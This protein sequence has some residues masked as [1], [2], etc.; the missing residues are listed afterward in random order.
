MTLSK[1]EK[2]FFNVID[3]LFHPI[4]I[5]LYSLYAIIHLY[6][7]YFLFNTESIFYLFVAFFIITVLLP[8]LVLSII[9]YYFLIFSSFNMNTKLERMLSV[10]IMLLFYIF[11]YFYFKNLSFPYFIGKLFGVFPI[12]LG[13]LLF[14]QLFYF[15]ISM[16]T[17]AI[18]S[19]L[20][21]IF[22]YRFQ[23]GVIAQFYLL[24]LIVLLSGLIISSRL[25]AGAHNLKEVLTG[26]VSG[27]IVAFF[28]MLIFV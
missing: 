28:S 23:L 22:F 15:K 17:Y 21:L 18:G 25:L 19:L 8:L 5:P 14:L 7:Q 11:L 13:V 6:S 27:L 4:F 9:K 3:V 12:I 2:I 16:H 1:I 24:S 10:F 20:G 26:F